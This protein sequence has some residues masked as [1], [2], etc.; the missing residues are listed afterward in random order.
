METEKRYGVVAIRAGEQRTARQGLP[1][2]FGISGQNAGARGISMNLVVIP[3]GATA[4][5]HCHSEFESTVYLIRGRVLTRYG[6]DLSESV[7]T[8]AGE[9]LYVGAH[10]WHQPTNLSDT[11]EAVAIVARNDP[12]EQE[13]VLLDAQECEKLAA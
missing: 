13:H 6:S 2:Y 11:E 4:E 8:N 1:Y 9:F 10:V 7:V 5:P 3:P 12:N